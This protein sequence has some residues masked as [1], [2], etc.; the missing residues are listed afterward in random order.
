MRYRTLICLAL[1]SA[2]QPGN[3]PPSHSPQAPPAPEQKAPANEEQG[4]YQVL[5]EKWKGPHGGLPPWDKLNDD[6]FLPAMERAAELYLKEVDA[7]ASNT[8][9]PTFDNTLVALERSGKPLDRVATLFFVAASSLNTPKIQK[10]TGIVRPRLSAVSDQVNFNAKLFSRVK[11][12]YE[13][14]KK[15]SL[16]PEQLRLVEKSYEGFVRRG[17]N[18]DEAQK[19]RLGEINQELAKHF[20]EFGNRVQG[21]E[22]TWVTLTKDELGGLP[23]ALVKT[24]EAAAKER[25]VSGYAVVNTR[26]AVDPFLTFSDK[27]ELREK[28]WKAF[29]NRGDN[30]N[31]NDTNQLIP[32]IV[33]LRAERAKL[34]G[35]KSHAHWRMSDTMAKEPERAERLMKRVWPAAVARVKQEVADMQKLATKEGKKFRIAPWDYRYYMEKVRKQRYA[36]DQN[37]FKNYFELEN[38]I[39]ASYYMAERLYGYAFEEITG[40]VGPVFHPDVRVIRVTNKAD[41]DACRLPLP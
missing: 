37:E 10:L 18:L 16:S 41:G 25:K 4:S 6:H 13:S 11:S 17:A 9:S 32:E 15:F 1:C 23:Q 14:R 35:Y 21:D 24:Y 3:K 40:S 5:L 38:M 20:T 26:S 36:L 2:C 28:V 31:K 22:D 8:A 27:R 30:G 29:V 34:L 39:R 33:K 19:K 12:V 7:I